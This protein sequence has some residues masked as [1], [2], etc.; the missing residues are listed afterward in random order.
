M[1]TDPT[2]IFANLDQL[3]SSSRPATILTTSNFLKPGMKG[4]RDEFLKGPIPLRWLTAATKLTGK[5]PL[6]VALALRFES[7][8]RKSLQV[9]LTTAILERFSV[10]RKAKY[11]ALSLLEKAGLIRVDRPPRKNPVVTILEC[12]D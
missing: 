12:P 4:G 2:D 9:K 8:R 1:T 6:A 10:N 5:S 7:A 3:R 11:K